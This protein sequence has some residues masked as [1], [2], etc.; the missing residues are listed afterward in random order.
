MIHFIKATHRKKLGLNL[1]RAPYGFVAL[2]LWYDFATYESFFARFRLRLHIRP[3]IMWSTGR[4]NV[5][6]E[7][8]DLYDLDLVPRAVL[9]DFNLLEAG[10]KSAN[11]SHAY[12]KPR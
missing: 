2:W 7:H 4:S 11:E 9:Q 1:Y 6:E 3:W 5:I 12:I 8:L 10:I